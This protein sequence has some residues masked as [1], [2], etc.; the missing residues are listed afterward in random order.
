[1]NTFQLA[2]R[3]DY[4]KGTEVQSWPVTPV[5]NGLGMVSVVGVWPVTQFKRASLAEYCHCLKIH[6]TSGG[7][8]HL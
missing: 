3:P 2:I 7:G 6:H 4:I 5:L 1:M 8:A